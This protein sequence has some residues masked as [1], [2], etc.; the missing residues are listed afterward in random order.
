MSNFRVGTS[1]FLS[2]QPQSQQVGIHYVHT[3]VHIWCV[4][5]LRS[6]F[7]LLQQANHCASRFP[8]SLY[9]SIKVDFPEA[10][11]SKN[12]LLKLFIRAV[13]RVTRKFHF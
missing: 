9:Q 7:W 4:P 3:H 5:A 11:I 8:N 13:A 10:P 1:S 12:I 2:Y 6:V